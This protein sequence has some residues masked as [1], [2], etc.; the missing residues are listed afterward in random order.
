MWLMLLLLSMPPPLVLVLLPEMV[1]LTMASITPSFM[2][3]PPP[4]NWLALG[5]WL[6]EMVVP[7]MTVPAIRWS[8]LVSW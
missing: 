4:V 6:P 7:A 2:M 1:E 3:P 8:R 5:A